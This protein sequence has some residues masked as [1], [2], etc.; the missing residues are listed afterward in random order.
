MPSIQC[1]LRGFGL[2][3]S[4]VAVLVPAAQAAPFVGGGVVVSLVG[5]GTTPIT[6]GTVAVPITLTEY[7]TAGAPTGGS[8]TLPTVDSGATYAVAGSMSSIFGFLK[9]SVDG[10]YLTL[11]GVNV[12]VGTQGSVFANPAFPNRV[13]ARI[14]AAGAVDS[15]T[16][17]VAA[18]TTPRS[19][20]TTNGT[21]LWWSGDSGGGGTTGGIRYLTLGGTTSGVPLAQG[22]SASTTTAGQ[23]APVPY[24]ARVL[25][26]HANQLYGSSNSTVGSGSNA[27]SMSGVFNV[28]AGLPTT[29]NQFGSLLVGS[30]RDSTFDFYFA[31]AST[32]YVADDDTTV[33]GTLDGISK[34]SL[35]G[36]TW[37]RQWMALPAGATGMR[38]LAGVTDT[39]S[40]TVELYGVTAAASGVQNQLVRL[41]DT[42]A[43]TSAPSFSVLA[44]PPANHLFRGVAMSPVA[45]PEPSSVALLVVGGGLA[46]ASGGLRGS[47][48]VRRRA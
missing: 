30:G 38:G 25:N 31:D 23:P 35:S 19:A 27:V 21:D 13:I 44:T 47:R 46:V 45:V 43:G 40:G 18:S 34:W 6:T 39:A 15:S 7:T 41:V 9:R 37:T 24:N 48:R 8:V 3:A 33:S 12:P 36:S 10:R 14:D 5:D 26:I 16:R 29:A 22:N 17:F 2:V 28:G 42:L 32:L 20:I 4:L 11:A 1:R